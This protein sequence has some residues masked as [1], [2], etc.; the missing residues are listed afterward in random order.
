MKQKEGSNRIIYH[1]FY[2]DA[3][4]LRT[5]YTTNSSA[6]EI[7]AQ[8]YLYGYDAAWNMAKRTN[9]AA[10]STYTVNNLNQVTADSG[11]GTSQTYDSNGN[12]V[13]QPGNG[14][15]RYEY[16]NENRLIAFDKDPATYSTPP[17][18][19][20]KY[21]ARGRLRKRIDYIWNSSYGVWSSAV[22]SG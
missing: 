4:E 7:T 2:D 22:W 13:T 8:R 17:R 10:I 20:F 9:N 5:A 3:G 14:T 1:F 6:A 16:D 21:D 18:V 11:G 15:E 19:E 12:R